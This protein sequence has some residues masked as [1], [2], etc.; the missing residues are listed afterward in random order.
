MLR[1]LSSFVSR[2][3]ELKN[4]KASTVPDLR[5]VE[6]TTAGN[7]NDLTAVLCAQD[8]VDMLLR[9]RQ[10]APGTEEIK[11]LE[12]VGKLVH[13]VVSCAAGLPLQTSCYA[14][15]TVSV[16]EQVKGGQWDGFA[17]RCVDYAMLNIARDLDTI[18]LL[19]K[20]Q[21]QA[22]CRTKLL[23]R[24]L[25]ILTR[26]GVVQ[27]GVVQASESGGSDMTMFDL[28]FL[29]VE[30]ATKAASE[31]HNNLSAASVLCFLVL[32]TIPYITDFGSPDVIG[33]RLLKPIE[34][35]LQKYES[36]FTPGTGI[37]AIL[38]K[39]EQKEEDD[40]EED[41][42]EEESDDDDDDD[43]AGQVCDSL[44]D[45]LRVCKSLGK[46]SSRFCLPIDS[47]WKGLMRTSTPN[48]E[49]GETE[50]QP[51]SYS[52][53][54]LYLAFKHECQTMTLL[55]R[56]DSQFKLE[57]FKLHGI[58]F[59]RLPIFGS[60]PDPDDEEDM[61]A[62]PKTEQLQAYAK[63]YGLLDRYFI[64]ETIRDCLTS[65]ESNITGT[66]LESG[67]AK[68]A[69]EEL[70]SIPHAFTGENPSLGFEYAILE[71]ILALISQTFEGSSLKHIYL[72]RVL[73]ELVRLDPGR[74]S[75]ALAFGMTNLFQDYMPALVPSAR[76]NLSRWFAFHLINTEYQWP[77]AYWQLW[78]P[79]ATSTK[80]SSRGAF[81]RRVL[82]AMAENVS[83]PKTVASS[84]FAEMKGLAGELIGRSSVSIEDFAAENPMDSL[85]TEILQRIWGNDE[86]AS[87]LGEF[88]CGEEVSSKV[89][90]GNWFR[91][92]VLIR[93]LLNPAKQAL[94][95]IQA[96]FESSSGNEDKMDEGEGAAKD[97]NVVITDAITRYRQTIIGAIA[98]DAETLGAN[99]DTI[100]LGGAFL[101]QRVESLTAFNSSVLEGIVNCLVRQKVVSGFSVLRWVLADAGESTEVV[102]RW[103][104]FATDSIQESLVAALEASV[105]GGITVDGGSADEEFWSQAMTHLSQA[106]HYSVKRVVILLSAS[107]AERRLNP[108]QVELLEGMKVFASSSMALMSSV[109][110][111]PSGTRKALLPHEIHQGFAKFNLSGVAL[112]QLCA[113]QENN[114]AVA[115]LQGS[116]QTIW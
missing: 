71:N 18:L 63:G 56:R 3:G 80:L 42:E 43:A 31:P 79:Y 35:L 20:D 60:P 58:V 95:I 75:P 96:S 62:A 27:E 36:T 82:N 24:Y 64:A 22:A 98:K 107:G 14:A 102:S 68:S 34:A 41:D 77:I 59:G 52:D 1:Q 54:P 101:L 6:S 113:G 106:L 4:I 5:A 10:P 91:T 53:Q 13:L 45:L 67:S 97:V 57:C 100:I 33:E 8:K 17:S 23:L 115:L 69:A 30:L 40:L 104:T 66:G 16:H 88:L 9:Y 49:G 28:L 48:P 65:Y 26:I 7:I 92:D 47:P 50:S 105:N 51:V 61:G 37:T 15:M 25:A 99:E 94:E 29:L 110:E 21:A 81:V 12:K 38:L 112:A 73:L 39:E 89:S 108:V 114:P 103:S 84:C 2:A 83:D 32:S 109:L 44:Q 11:P 90:G 19:G 55:M 85:Q 74:F 87:L 86:D 111:N 93:G 72:S 116:L 76:D 78:E 46:E 70:L